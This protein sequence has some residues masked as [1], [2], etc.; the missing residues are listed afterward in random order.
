MR[1][2]EHRDAQ[3]Y[4]E[5]VIGGGGE[6]LEAEALEIEKV[7]EH[8][9]GSEHRWQGKPDQSGHRHERIAQQMAAQRTVLSDRPLARAVL[10]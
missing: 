10:M 5:I 8:Q 4:G 2:H 1:S 7:L 9:P 6:V 3:H